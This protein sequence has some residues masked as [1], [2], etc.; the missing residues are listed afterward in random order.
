MK[1][2]SAGRIEEAIPVLEQEV[3]A[4]EVS[5]RYPLGLAYRDGTGVAA[6]PYRA[7]VL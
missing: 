3:A 1:L 5:A 2:Y 4:G 6:D 7:E